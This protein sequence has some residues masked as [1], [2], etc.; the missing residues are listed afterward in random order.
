LS[1]IQRLLFPLV[2]ALF[3]SCNCPSPIE[4]AY[5]STAS[6]TVTPSPKTIQS[7][8][9]AIVYGPLSGQLTLQAALGETLKKVDSDYGEKPQLGK[10]L[11][12]KAGTVWEG[13]FTVNNK[14]QNNTPMTG[15]AIIYAPQ[16]GTAGGATLID[17]T[18]NFPKSANSMLQRLMQDITNSAKVA[19]QGTAS[20]PATSVAAATLRPEITSSFLITRTPPHFSSKRS[21][22][23]LK[24]RAYSLRLTLSSRPKT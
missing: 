11:Q 5:S 7:P 10:M 3:F 8:G 12:N 13:F 23:W 19:P 21:I 1:L 20:A 17:T 24:N 15:L 9:G 18:A 14:K 6:N 22:S 4:A 2:L 16:A